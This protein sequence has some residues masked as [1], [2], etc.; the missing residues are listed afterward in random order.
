[1]LWYLPFDMSPDGSRLAYVALSRNGTRLYRRALDS[2]ESIAVPGTEG[3]SMPFFS[4]DGE[5]IGFF[6][7]G[8]LKKGP[9]GGGSPVALATARI[10][11]GGSWGSDGTIVYAPTQNGGLWRVSSQ[12]G[13]PEELTRPDFKEKGYTHCW[14]Q[15]LEGGRGILFTVWGS[16]SSTA[17]IL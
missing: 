2:S 5:W 9:W 15:V 8:K 3:A 1:R 4:P 13:E 7:D 6:A 14:P 12:G 11:V 10:P 16:T 17:N